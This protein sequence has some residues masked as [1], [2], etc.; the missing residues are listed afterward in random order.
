M[1]ATKRLSTLQ[2]H[3]DAS[4]EELEALKDEVYE[5]QDAIARKIAQQM[6]E[7]VQLD[8]YWINNLSEGLDGMVSHGMDYQWDLCLPLVIHEIP[9]PK[10]NKLTVIREYDY[11]DHPVLLEI[12]EQLPRN[13]F[14]FQCSSDC[15][16]RQF[17]NRINV[18]IFIASLD[19]VPEGLKYFM[20]AWRSSE[21]LLEDHVK[22]E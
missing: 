13:L 2:L 18:P 15:P 19:R 20:R 8:D 1:S 9:D 17:H 14:R 16:S 21:W 7:R 12:R 5:A 4:F 11:K 3:P 10:T 6:T 22:I